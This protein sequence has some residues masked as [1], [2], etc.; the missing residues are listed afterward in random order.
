MG[1]NC[2]ELIDRVLEHSKEILQRLQMI[3]GSSAKDKLK[4][5]ED[6]LM[7]YKKYVS[8]RL[9]MTKCYS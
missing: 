2:Q 7:E 1:K 8:S 5:L 6:D 4:P 3:A 9:F